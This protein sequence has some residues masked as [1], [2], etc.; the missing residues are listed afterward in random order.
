MAAIGIMNGPIDKTI[1]FFLESKPLEVR[2]Y[3]H[4]LDLNSVQ[5]FLEIFKFNGAV[6]KCMTLSTKLTNVCRKT[7]LL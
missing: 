6:F 4:S 7:T 2:V 1:I 3:K 5:I